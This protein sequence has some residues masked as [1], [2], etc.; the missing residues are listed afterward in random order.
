M[1]EEEAQEEGQVIRLVETFSIILG[2]VGVLDLVAIFFVSR[3]ENKAW[4]E[5]MEAIE[6]KYT[7]GLCESGARR[8]RAKMRYR[9]IKKLL[10][11]LQNG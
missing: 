2:I 11:G 9:A 1:E 5:K 10:E 6:K 8:A 3:R 7:A 4:A